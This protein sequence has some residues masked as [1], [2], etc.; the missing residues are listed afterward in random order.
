MS[1]PL[2]A[3][4]V[5]PVDLRRAASRF[6]TGVALV[7]A[8]GGLALV[9]ASFISASLEPPLVAFAPSRTSLTW[10]SM[11]RTGR[12]GVSVLDATHAHGI[13]ERARPGAD[14]LAGLDVELVEGVPVVRDALAAFVCALE[15][16]HPAG[17]HSIVLGRVLALRHGGDGPPLV[18]FAGGFSTL[19]HGL[20]P[21]G[22][23]AGDG[24]G[25]GGRRGRGVADV[26]GVRG[27]GEGEVVEEPPVAGDGLG[28]D[29]GRARFDVGERQ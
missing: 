21:V 5:A 22:D 23:H 3:T 24:Q 9:V 19:L 29:P 17:D 13:R 10:R 6:A 11:R 25:R 28:S 26:Q 18:F 15:A 2:A 7:T 8:P 1:R 16:E 4:A 20:Q 27:G 14:R 12:F